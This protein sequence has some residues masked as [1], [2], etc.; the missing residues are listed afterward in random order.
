MTPQTGGCVSDPE[1]P[2][3]WL[4]VDPLTAAQRHERDLA[5]YAHEQD[6]Y[7]HVATLST[8]SVVLLSTF[9]ERLTVQPEWKH[10]VGVALGSFGASLVGT[11]W[12]QVLSVVHVSR[13]PREEPSGVRAAGGFLLMLLGFGGFLAGVLALV[14]FGIKNL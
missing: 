6:L 8:G 12:M 4:T 10:L 11:V 1:R 7:K 13:D 3:A 5:S 2:D 9:L 14:L